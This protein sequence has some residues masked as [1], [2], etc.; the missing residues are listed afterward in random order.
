MLGLVPAVAGFVG[1]PLEVRHVT[2]SS[3]QLGAALG[4]LGPTLLRE[5]TFWWCVAGITV[6]GVLNLTVSFGLA[7]AVALR[8][9]G[10]RLKQRKRVVSAIWRRL[11]TEPLSFLRPPKTD[12]PH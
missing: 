12:A 8:S 5:P 1:L 10:V 7:F 6:T 11:R 2:L 3:G 4:A 9:R